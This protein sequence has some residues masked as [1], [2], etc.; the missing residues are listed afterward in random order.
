MSGGHE[1][2][3]AAGRVLE[4][5][6]RRRPGRRVPLRAD[7]PDALDLAPLALRVDPLERR[8]RPPSSR[9]RFTPTTTWSP[10]L[11]RPLDPVGRLLDLALLEAGLDGRERAAHR[12]DLGQVGRARPP[13]AR[14]VR[15]STKYEP[16]SGSGVS[17]TPAS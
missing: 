12:V 17:V 1:V 13:P 14:S 16:A 10:A 8:R 5:P 7:P 2:V 3:V 11:D 9:K 15:D 6:H 4:P